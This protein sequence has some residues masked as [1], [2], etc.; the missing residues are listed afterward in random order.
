MTR[1]RLVFLVLALVAAAYPVVAFQTPPGFFEGFCPPV[2]YKFLKPP[3][4]VRAGT[5]PGAGHS[6]IKIT[7]DSSGKP[8]VSP[9]YVATAD[10]NPQAQ[11][12]FIPDAFQ[13]P[14]GGSDEIIDIKPVADYPAAPG[15]A[16]VTNVYL[17]SSSTPMTKTSN[18]RLL[19]STVLPAPSSIY[20]AQPGGAWQALPSSASTSTGCSDISSQ[21]STTGY[22]MAGYPASSTNSTSGAKVGGGQLLPIL[23]AL[24]ILIV[25]LAGIPLAVVRRRQAGAEEEPPEPPKGRRRKNRRRT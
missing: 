14:A 15:I 24:A 19:Y 21:V 18:L 22:F 23:V 11:L 12:S 3:P 2:D 5:P 9:G 17:V 10:D 20:V 8:I 4:Q 6:A 13:L 1:A 16:V 7:H 25:V